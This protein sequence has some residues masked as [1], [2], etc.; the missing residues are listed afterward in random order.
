TLNLDEV[1]SSAQ[2]AMPK[3][4]LRPMAEILRLQHEKMRDMKNFEESMSPK[5]RSDMMEDFL[6]TADRASVRSLLERATQRLMSM[7]PSP[8]K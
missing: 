3:I 2:K 1:A 6:R 7:S 4:A 5:E 8:A